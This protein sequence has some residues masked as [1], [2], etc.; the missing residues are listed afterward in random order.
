MILRSIHIASWRCFVESVEVGPFQEGLNVL[1]AP[2]ATGKSTLFEG[3]LRGLLDGHRVGGQ[4]AAA[5]RPWGRSLA[6]TV[7]V[8]F[9]H[10]GT[11]YRIMKRFLDNPTSRL[12]RKENGRFVPLADNDE[13][14]K[15]VRA[16]L[17]RNAPMKGLARL[18]N[19]GLAQVLWAPQGDLA[20]KELSGDVVADIRASL[21]TQVSSAGPVEKGVA[22]LYGQFYTSG[23]KL[24]SGQNAP[25][26]VRLKVE[27][28]VALGRKSAALSQQQ[29]FDE[30]ARRI[31]DLRARRTQ[32]KNDEEDIKKLL[33]ETR[34]RA[35]SYRVLSSERKQR[36][37]RLKAITAQHGELKSHLEA[38]KSARK[39]FKEAGET[40]RNLE[41]AMPLQQCEMESREK[42]DAQAK[43]ALEDIRN[44]LYS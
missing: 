15:K 7:T 28:Q 33:G 39:E 31:E 19:W 43:A 11:D 17:T 22:E 8:E 2:N 30:A 40:L 3:L 10:D 34:L 32:A 16:I 14:D 27:L 6:P 5:I 25:I 12:E 9:S 26:V 20:F 4:E 35:E 18:E 41:E 38:I 23:G 42:E 44:I 36:E 24:K 37:E 21:G 1:H 13:A 29:A